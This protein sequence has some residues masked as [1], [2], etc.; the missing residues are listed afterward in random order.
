[1]PGCSA[2]K[3]RVRTV[4]AQVQ[5]VTLYAPCVTNENRPHHRDEGR[6]ERTL[7]EACFV[8]RSRTSRSILFCS[9]ASTYSRCRSG[10]AAGSARWCREVRVARLVARMAR[11]RDAGACPR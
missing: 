7:K 6:E 9:R 4:Q 1:M 11:W 8:L 5:L 10:R 3:T 2:R